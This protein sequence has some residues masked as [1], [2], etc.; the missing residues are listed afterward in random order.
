MK[1]FMVVEKFELLVAHVLYDHLG[2]GGHLSVPGLWPFLHLLR[3][4][5]V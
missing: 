4:D 3:Y 1:F 5:S 2:N